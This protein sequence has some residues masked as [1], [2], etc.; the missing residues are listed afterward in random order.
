MSYPGFEQPSSKKAWLGFLV[1]ALLLGLIEPGIIF[2]LIGVG[3][4]L[5]LAY[6]IIQIVDGL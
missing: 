3:L 2:Y 4:T 5:G 6:I 1:F